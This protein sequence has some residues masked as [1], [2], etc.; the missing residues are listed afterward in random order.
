MATK[1]E[2]LYLEI[3]TPLL[4]STR[5]EHERILDLWT[6]CIPEYLPDRY[7][8]SEPIDRAFDLNQRDAILSHL[9]W[10]FLAV[11]DKP[12]MNSSIWMRSP[13]KPLH[14]SWKLSFTFGEANVDRLISFL[15]AA[16]KEL[17]ADFCCLTLFTDSEI[18]FGRRNRSA[19]NL[20]KNATK[21]EFSIYSQFLQQCLPDVYWV[22]I[23]GPPYVEM[24]GSERIVSAPISQTEVID[25]KLI[26][27]QLTPRLEDV[28]DAMSFRDLKNRVKAHLGADAFYQP[29]QIGL[30]RHPQFIWERDPGK[31]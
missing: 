19:W 18:A 26:L 16:A 25:Q 20:D 29:G 15:R 30:A 1:V 9:R 27:M 28:R 4:L 21:F 12:K 3:Q 2:K 17:A 14:S 24:F 7:G 13:N 31:R 22:T 11:K 10:S 23:F 5:R 6:S 8:N